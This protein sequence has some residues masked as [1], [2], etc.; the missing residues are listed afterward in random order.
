M[1]Y[2]SL[3]LYEFDVVDQTMESSSRIHIT[4]GSFYIH[5][6]HDGS[7]KCILLWYIDEIYSKMNN[8][9]VVGGVGM[10]VS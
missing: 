8:F 9:I 5:Y 3:D 2:S 10:C 7:V 4:V 1:K 6:I